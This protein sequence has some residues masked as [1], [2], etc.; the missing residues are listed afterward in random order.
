MVNKRETIYFIIYISDKR[1]SSFFNISLI[2]CVSFTYIFFFPY[3]F[4]FNFVVS[5]RNVHILLCRH[6]WAELSLL[7]WTFLSGKFFPDTWGG[8]G[9]RGRVHVHPVHP[10]RTRLCFLFRF[11][12]KNVETS[13][14][15]SARKRKSFDS[16]ACACFTSCSCIKVVFTVKQEL[17][18]LCLFLSLFLRRLC[19]PG[20]I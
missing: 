10:L 14:R 11:H 13:I 16:F 1:L 15:A 4:R 20:L 7:F 8:G 6:I 18:F 2:L 19:K 9:G 17:L 5:E 3:L 12:E